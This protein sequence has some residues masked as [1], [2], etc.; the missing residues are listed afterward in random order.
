MT[1]RVS[2]LV[3]AHDDGAFLDA[4]LASIAA[5]GIESLEVVVADDASAD[6][7][8]RIAAAWSARDPRFRLSRVERNLGMNRNWNRALAEARGDLVLKLDADDAF[9]P[10]ALGPLVTEFDAVPELLF[11]ACRAVDCDLE[12]RPAGPYRGEEALRLH[13]LDP[14]R[15]H[16]RRGLAWLRLCFDDLQ[17]WHSCAQLYRR[18]DLVALGG[19]DERWIASDTAL[20]LAA[21]ALDRPVVHRPEAG[22]LYRRRRG[23]SSQREHST[24][25]ARLELNQI[26]L[27]SLAGNAGR[28]KPWGRGL[29]QNWWRLWRRF[30]ADRGD[31]A[32]WGALGPER[33]AE[34]ERLQ[35]ETAT[36]PPPLAVR[37][38]GELRWRVWRL[39]EALRPGSP[40]GRSAA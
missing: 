30:L 22:L 17:P 14:E 12:L 13:G 29:R 10:G 11:A 25:A 19:W 28:L 40:D 39:R 24:G 26:A 37:L 1:P 4:N 3:P 32:A 20:I 21:L 27:R 9:A 23:S 15:R 5:Q 8:P 35:D 2:I 6:D 33:R 31:A 18:R 38:E 7:T 16:E 34:L 36:M